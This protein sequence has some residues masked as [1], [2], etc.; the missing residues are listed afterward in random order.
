MMNYDILPNKAE[1]D[2]YIHDRTPTGSFLRSVLTNNLKEACG[3]A[4]KRNQ[5]YLCLYV[6]YLYNEAP[7]ECWGSELSV[8]EWL[9]KKEERDAIR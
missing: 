7:G 1:L 4:D 3:R 9:N 2:R 5:P 8:Q 6:Q